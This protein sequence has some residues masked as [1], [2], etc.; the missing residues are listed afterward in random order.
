MSFLGAG[1]GPG[2]GADALPPD[3]AFLLAAG[4]EPGR[5]LAA[6]AEARRC[7]G[8]GAG[9][10]LRGGLMAEDTYYRALARALGLPYL[11]GPIALGPA[12][13]FP[14][15]LW[16][17]T[18]PLAGIPGH[19]V[20]APEGYEIEGLLTGRIPLVRT[21]ALT[22][23][24][25]L[26]EAVFAALPHAV[27]SHAAEALESHRPEWA[28][29][30]GLT[31][32][33]VAGLGLAACASLLI[34]S[35][36]PAGLALGAVTAVQGGILAT[37]SF[38]LGALFLACPVEPP[39]SEAALSDRDLPVYT[40]LVP[41]YREAGSVPRIVSALARLDYPASKLDIKFVVE[42][43]DAG[44]AAALAGIPLPARFEVV[45]AP[46]GAPR[47]KPRALNVAL[48][49][50]RGECLVVYDA[51]DVP[52]PGQL[53]L[54]AARFAREPPETACLQGRLVIDN[55][56]DSWLTRC[57]ALE[58]AGL[59]DVLGPALAAW[60]L[61]TPLGGTSTHF[62]TPVLRALHGWDAWNVTEDADLGLRLALA[63]YAVGDLPSA[64]IEEA[65]ARLGPWLRQRVRWMKGF[66][67]TTVTHGRRPLR[68]LRRL[69]PL[70]AL[71]AL[72]LV[73]GTVVSALVYP[74][75]MGTAA[76][77]FWRG[78]EAGPAFWPNLPHGL[79]LTV[80]GT[81]L[82][83]MMLPAGLGAVRRGWH[84]LLP[85][86][87]LLPFY[88]LLLSLAAWLCLVEFAWA[89]SRWN[90]TEHGLFRTSRTGLLRRRARR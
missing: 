39:D 19:H 31:A 75:L 29:R 89:P 16:A 25:R 85:F 8:D 44:T 67:Q 41:L 76:H 82:A 2:T 63:G 55:A 80:F 46:P 70:D 88:Y 72:T 79:A 23:P 90:K 15:S 84:D 77:A 56:G 22:A 62:R 51:E 10:L 59:F 52:D 60:R 3:L 35:G 87:L 1:R 40:V 48:P 66:V 64:T 58:Y 32:R 30:P 33:Q 27:A 68:S 43:D 18:A 5:L 83:A 7:G 49:L 6:A 81:G 74:V 37:A 26:R 38:R 53:G 73:P 78:L 50:A 34:L 21:A 42:A 45:V 4:A 14:Q 20:R 57:F 69:G 9:A 12:T 28:Y 36:L 65:P 24:T 54:A 47:T 13:R 86:V 11:D 61:P 71:C 17:R